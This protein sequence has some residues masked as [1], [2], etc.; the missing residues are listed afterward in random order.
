MTLFLPQS[1][2]VI[3]QLTNN[4]KTKIIQYAEIYKL[5]GRRK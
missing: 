5:G 1:K 3:L 4:Y 2:F